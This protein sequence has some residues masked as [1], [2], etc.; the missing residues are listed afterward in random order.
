MSQSKDTETNSNDLRTFVASMT[1]SEGNRRVGVWGF[2]EK[3]AFD[4]FNKEIVDP[5]NALMPE[6]ACGV[7]SDDNFWTEAILPYRFAGLS[8]QEIV[9]VLWPQF[10]EP[11]FGPDVG[12]FDIEASGNV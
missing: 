2:H 7:R 8:I 1:E 4:D 6:G 3:P 9:A 12:K 10:R 5:G 11:K